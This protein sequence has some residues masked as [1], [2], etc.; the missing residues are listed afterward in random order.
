VV[1]VGSRSVDKAQEFIDRLA[2]GDKSIKAYG[3][4]AEVFADKVSSQELT[5][6]SILTHT[7]RVS[8]PSTLARL[9]LTT[10]ATPP[11]P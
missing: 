8:T 4:Y 6:I 3:T 10:I 1:A 7:F 9:T 2:G 11:M 5:Y